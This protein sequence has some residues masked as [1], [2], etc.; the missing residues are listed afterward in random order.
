[1]ILNNLNAFISELQ[2][3]VFIFGAVYKY[4]Y[5]RQST[6]NSTAAVSHDP[7]STGQDGREWRL[8]TVHGVDGPYV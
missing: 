6:G 5:R 4:S 8:A 2:G 7:Q 1:M 3:F